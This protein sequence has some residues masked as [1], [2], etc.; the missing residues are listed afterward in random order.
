[1]HFDFWRPWNAIP[2]ADE[3][4]NP[5]TSPDPTWTALITA[6]YP[7]H[8]SGHIC[9]DGAHTAALRMFFGTDAPEG[10]FQI[11]SASTFLLPSDP[12]GSRRSRRPGTAAGRRASPARSPPARGSRSA[13]AQ[14]DPQLAA[15]GRTRLPARRCRTEDG[16]HVAQLAGRA[17]ILAIRARARGSAARVPRAAVAAP[18]AT[19]V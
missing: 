13:S 16:H 9:N 19:R 7:E 4:P 18:A 2:R 10:G 14:S 12:R 11:T 1:Y 3:D 15:N 5:A 17:P 6:P 8:P